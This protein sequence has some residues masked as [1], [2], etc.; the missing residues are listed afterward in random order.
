MGISL[1]LVL[2]LPAPYDLICVFG[3]Y[4]LV[5]FL[6]VKG[7]IKGYGGPGG[8][9]GL[10]GSMF[11]STSGNDRSRPLKYYCMNCGKEHREIACPNCGSKMKRAG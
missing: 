4:V 8:I 1:I 9:K 2:V 6:R 5:N 11:P 3:L 7:I 10:F